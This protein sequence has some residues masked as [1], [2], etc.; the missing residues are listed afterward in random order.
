MK[1]VSGLN[2]SNIIGEK[3]SETSLFDWTVKKGGD[4]TKLVGKILICRL[5]TYS[6]YKTCKI[7]EITRGTLNVVQCDNIFLKCSHGST[8]YSYI[9][10]KANIL[11][12]RVQF[13]DSTDN[14]C[15]I[16]TV[17]ICSDVYSK[18]IFFEESIVNGATIPLPTSSDMSLRDLKKMNRGGNYCVRCGKPLTTLSLLTGVVKICNECEKVLT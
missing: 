17:S 5:K 14:I 9:T 4:P 3:M 15:G 16:I 11:Q 12:M 18:S 6:D 13:M 7:L 8:C 10:D 2:F 1:L